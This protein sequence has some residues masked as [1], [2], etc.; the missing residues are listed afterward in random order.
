MIFQPIEPDDPARR[1]QPS[2]IVVE[3]CLPADQVR[4]R[5]DAAVA[6]GGR[7]VGDQVGGRCTV[8]DPEGN[9]L[10]FIG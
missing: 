10:I 5:V 2:R 3:L 4:T 9:A 7:V 1:A 8:L 6:A